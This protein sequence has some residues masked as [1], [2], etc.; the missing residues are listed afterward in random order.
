MG[1]EDFAL[2]TE[3][4]VSSGRERDIRSDVELPPLNERQQALNLDFY[5]NMTYNVLQGISS[6]IWIYSSLRIT[7][8]AHSDIRGQCDI[9]P[10]D[11]SRLPAN[12]KQQVVSTSRISKPAA[13]MQLV[14]E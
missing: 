8:L 12:A 5:A 6:I 4:E 11:R 14:T 1:R 9:F 7:A 13:R 10:K 3:T 2:T